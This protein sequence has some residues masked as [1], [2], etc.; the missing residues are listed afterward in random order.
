MLVLAISYI[1]IQK[2]SYKTTAALA[3]Q[4]TANATCGSLAQDR[5]AQGSAQAA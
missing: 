1:L 5:H 3:P 4:V 2:F